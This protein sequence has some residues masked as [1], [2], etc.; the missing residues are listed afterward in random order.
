MNSS[1]LNS[2]IQRASLLRYVS[3]SFAESLCIFEQSEGDVDQATAALRG[4]LSAI[5]ATLPSDPLSGAV[6]T[7]ARMTYFSN[8]GC[9]YYSGGRMFAAA[10]YCGKALEICDA[11]VKSEKNDML[12]TFRLHLPVLELLSNAGVAYLRTGRPGAAKQ[13]F[14]RLSYLRPGDPMVWLRQAECLISSAS[15]T[16]SPPSKL[17]Y[18]MKR[19]AGDKINLLK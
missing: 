17:T 2:S 3:V 6:L 16:C 8:L 4:R 7:W 11:L 5:L 10:E 12:K 1:I 14:E 19:V 9:L 15:M 18:S 13:C